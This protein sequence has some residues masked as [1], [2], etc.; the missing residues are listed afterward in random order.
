MVLISR[1]GDIRIGHY[2]DNEADYKMFIN[3]L[4]NAQG[5][6]I[7]PGSLKQIIYD[8]LNEYYSDIIDRKTLKDR[9]EKRVTLYLDENK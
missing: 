1:D 7:L 2:L 5:L 6:K 3:L 9:L 4:N 8:E